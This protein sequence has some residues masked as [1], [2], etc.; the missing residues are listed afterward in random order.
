MY[1]AAWT[2][3]EKNP[4]ETGVGDDAN[5]VRYVKKLTAVL[6]ADSLR[7]RRVLDFGAGRGALMRALAGQ[8]AMSFGIE[9]FGYERLHRLGFPVWRTIQD[10]PPSVTFDAIVSIDVIEHLPAPWKQLSALRRLLRP[11]GWLF[12]ATPNPQGVN[13]LLTGQHWREALKPGHLLFFTSIGLESVLLRTGFE[14][15]DRLR[16]ESAGL[17]GFGRRLLN[18]ALVKAR[19]DGELC[20]LAWKPGHAEVSEA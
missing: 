3:P 8:G 17:S 14:R 19:R 12:V 9:P 13:A 5:A 10:V 7:D 1:E 15:Y 2:A 16:V 11:G 4:R 18:R 6:G 20:Y